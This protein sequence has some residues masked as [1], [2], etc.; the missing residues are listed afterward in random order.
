MMNLYQL[1]ILPCKGEVAKYHTIIGRVGSKKWYRSAAWVMARQQSILEIRRNWAQVIK[2]EFFSH[3]Y[4]Q[5]WVLFRKRKLF[6]RFCIRKTV[7]LSDLVCHLKCLSLLATVYFRYCYILCS[8]TL[9]MF[10]MNKTFQ[11]FTSC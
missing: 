5:E 11:F 10:V 7:S 8:A 1:M 9:F 4:P 3:L 2:E 6:R